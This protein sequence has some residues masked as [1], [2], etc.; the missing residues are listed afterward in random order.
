MDENEV[1]FG[2]WDADSFQSRLG[3]V[4]CSDLEP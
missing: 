4:Q 3:S 2:R 1:K